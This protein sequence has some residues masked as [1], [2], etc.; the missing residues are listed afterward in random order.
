MWNRGS[1]A[2]DPVLAGPRQALA[3]IPGL[4]HRDGGGEVAHASGSRPSAGRSCRRCTAGA[5]CRAGRPSARWRAA[6][7]PSR[8][9]EKDTT[10]AAAG[11]GLVGPQANPTPRPRR[12]SPGR[13]GRRRRASGPSAASLPMFVVARIRAPLS[14]SLCASSRSASRG[15]R[16]TRR[17]PA[18]APPKKARDGRACSADRGRA[19]RP[20]RRRLA[21]QR[22]AELLGPPA[23]S[24]SK[25]I[26][27]R[28][29]RS[30]GA[31]RAPRRPHR[32]ACRQGR[33]LDGSVPADALGIGSFPRERAVRLAAT[34]R[35]PRCAVWSGHRQVLPP[36][37]LWPGLFMGVGPGPGKLTPAA[38]RCKPAVRKFGFA[39]MKA[40]L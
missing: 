14:V 3:R 39:A 20:P 4:V 36:D 8:N 32:G 19:R 12:R 38:P 26:A 18:L 40:G 16:C 28:G 11:I 1:D 37:G 29:T 17:T 9:R 31:D 22:G 27:A 24:S 5:R 2:D 25:G 23:P 15:L 30:P 33:E 13:E 7:A 35:A 10:Q 21:Q 34:D 6:A